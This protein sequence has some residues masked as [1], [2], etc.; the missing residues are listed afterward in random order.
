MEENSENSNSKK[1][2]NI[3]KIELTTTSFD[4][5]TLN[6]LTQE[7]HK[8]SKKESDT[9][10]LKDLFIDPKL[11]AKTKAVEQSKNLKSRRTSVLRL[12]DKSNNVTKSFDFLSVDTKTSHLQHTTIPLKSADSQTP[13]KSGLNGIG[14]SKSQPSL[15]R[16][17]NEPVNLQYHIIKMFN[18]AFTDAIY[19]PRD[20]WLATV[21]NIYHAIILYLSFFMECYSTQ[22]M[23]QDT[24]SKKKTWRIVSL[25]F[26]VQLSLYFL[27]DVILYPIRKRRHIAIL[28]AT[29]RNNKNDG[30]NVIINYKDIK[31]TKNLFKL[32]KGF[33]NVPHTMEF[34]GCLPFIIEEFFPKTR[35]INLNHYGLISFLL[36]CCRLYTCLSIF[37]YLKNRISKFFHIIIRAIK[38]SIYEI[39]S[40]IVLYFIV[41]IFCSRVIFYADLSKCTLDEASQNWKRQYK[42]G[43]INE[44]S[45]SCELQ[46][47]LDAFWYTFMTMTTLGFGDQIPNTYFG[48][49]M[50]TLAFGATPI[51]YSLPSIVITTKMITLII[52]DTRNTATKDV[53][54]KH[55]K[56]FFNMGLFLSGAG[57][58]RRNKFSRLNKKINGN[59]NKNVKTNEDDNEQSSTKFGKIKKNKGKGKDSNEH[60]NNKFNEQ[61]KGKYTIPLNFESSVIDSND[62]KKNSLLPV[63]ENSK[64]ESSIASSV[65]PLINNN[66]NTVSSIDTKDSKDYS[67]N[68]NV[69][70]NSNT[71]SN[72]NSNSNSPKQVNDNNSNINDEIQEVTNIISNSQQLYESPDLK[73]EKENELESKQE[74]EPQPPLLYESPKEIDSSELQKVINQKND[75]L[76]SENLT[77][78]MTIKKVYKDTSSSVGKPLTAIFENP[79]SSQINNESNNTPLPTPSSPSASNSSMNINKSNK[80]LVSNIKPFPKT[81]FKSLP[82]STSNNNE[83][84]N[85][86]TIFDYNAYKKMLII[87][88]ILLAC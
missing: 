40:V 25:I 6:K 16:D 43:T 84:E 83:I 41:M 88:I 39:I 74:V 29:T 66:T 5:Y 48:K 34:L 49:I 33:I 59:K 82:V 60:K 14:M 12:P 52:H 57:N 10:K 67:F 17:M 56:R 45:L 51:L 20:S 31:V 15:A 87:K 35:I 81:T 65:L 73:E 69:N 37:Y 22:L 18:H 79:Q 86:S 64:Y 62:K 44:N 38:D 26:F 76:N 68:S 53:A 30:K 8:E 75:I 77:S 1:Q 47:N 46:S 27:A 42:N 19:S 2:F 61:V 24:K 78:S 4:N 85:E 55:K 28:E 21:F 11:E 3:P 71:N 32:Y 50:A 63:P 23:T 80:D 9:I 13:L 70:T 36:M 58:N 7:S 54:K 72:N